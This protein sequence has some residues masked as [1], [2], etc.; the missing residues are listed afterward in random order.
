M[1]PTPNKW[2]CLAAS[3][4]IALD[5]DLATLLSEV[6]HDGSEIIFPHLPE[7]FCRRAFHYQEFIQSC[8]QR[9]RACV[10]IEA[11]PLLG[12]TID[13]QVLPI[14][15]SGGNMMR[16]KKL[17]EDHQGVLV[18]DNSEGNPHAVAWNRQSCY[19]P[20]GCRI[21]SADMFGVRELLAL[22]PIEIKSS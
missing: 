6:G 10:L 21:Y 5:V 3:F 12:T 8:L 14:Y 1:Q 16:M 22:I 15:V 2:S 19:D 9:S 11:I 7:P 4:A 18:G 20:N 17:M 13:N